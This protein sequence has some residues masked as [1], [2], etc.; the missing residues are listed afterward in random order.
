MY[1]K[2]VLKAF[3]K[4]ESE[5]PGKTTKTQVSEYISSVLLNDY[6]T[7]IS[8]RTLRNLF[9][10]ANDVETHRDISIN[11]DYV[12]DLCKYLGY[13]NYNAFIK[14]TSSQIKS[15]NKVV[16]FYI[17]TLDNTPYLFYYYFN[18]HNNHNIQP[19][20]LDGLG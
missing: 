3:K 8:G 19:T 18:Y 14:D 13:E 17:K 11:S 4:G 2:V 7:Q 1:K 15:K 9:N 6:K 12:Q 10:D 16:Y 20:T 5:I